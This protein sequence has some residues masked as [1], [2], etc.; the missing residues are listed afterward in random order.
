MQPL[1]DARTA[2]GCAYRF[3]FPWIFLGTGRKNVRARGRC[4][5]CCIVV[6][7]FPGSLLWRKFQD[8]EKNLVLPPRF[9]SPPKRE[10]FEIGNRICSCQ[11][12][13]SELFRLRTMDFER[14]LSP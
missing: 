5:R 4:E 14:Y 10:A 7:E 9:V 1:F 8:G 2:C 13:I 6:Q 11:R 3:P 12:A